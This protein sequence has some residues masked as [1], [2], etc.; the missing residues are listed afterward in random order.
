MTVPMAGLMSGP[1]CSPSWHD[2][3]RL[4]SW[5]LALGSV[6]ASDSTVR[7]KVCRVCQ[8]PPGPDVPSASSTAPC[9]TDASPP[10]P[11]PSAPPNVHRPMLVPGWRR[12]QDG[13]ATCARWPQ[14]RGW[15]HRTKRS[16]RLPELIPCGRGPVLSIV[17]SS[18]G[19]AESSLD[20]RSAR[21]KAL[22]PASARKGE[23]GP[24]IK[25]G[26]WTRMWLGAVVSLQLNIIG[27]RTSSQS[28]AE[29][30]TPPDEFPSPR[31]LSRVRMCISSCAVACLYEILHPSWY[32]GIFVPSTNKHLD[33]LATNRQRCEVADL[34]PEQLR[35]RPSH[36]FPLQLV[37]LCFKHGPWDRKDVSPSDSP[38]PRIPQPCSSAGRRDN[39][40]STCWDNPKGK[41]TSEQAIPP[42]APTG[43]A[44]SRV[45]PAMC[46]H[47]AAAHAPN[48]KPRAHHHLSHQAL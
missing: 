8:V 30:K 3:L 29:R 44:D 1:P 14:S 41:S 7:I 12:I 25:M 6:L 46:R 5:A 45:E 42:Q 19:R 35:N 23:G 39:P 2:P 20:E 40:S 13:R 9:A 38:W 34:P 31:F 37:I 21:E 10:S 27:P 4:G 26:R 33:S 18:N 43:S 36:W 28:L 47:R 15:L 16:R 24:W 17:Y 48:S 22:R 32:L 11:S